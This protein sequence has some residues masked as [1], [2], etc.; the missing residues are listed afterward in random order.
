MSWVFKL[1]TQFRE[2]FSW[3]KILFKNHISSLSHH[4]LFLLRIVQVF[5]I[6]DPLFSSIFFK[7]APHS[8]PVLQ[9]YEATPMSFAYLYLIGSS[10]FSRNVCRHAAVWGG[11]TSLLLFHWE[12]CDHLSFFAFKCSWRGGKSSRTPRRVAKDQQ[13]T[14]SWLWPLGLQL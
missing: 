2:K 3:M 12:V 9:L 4:N 7:S 6:Y 8:D 13:K 14:L 1:Q 10:A 5:S 11:K